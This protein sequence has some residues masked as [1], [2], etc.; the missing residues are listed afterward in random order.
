MEPHTLVDE[1]RDARY[2]GLLL[3]EV[4][5]NADPEGLKRV[6]VHVPGILDPSRWALPLGAM[7]GVHEGV[8]A[9]PKVGSN[10]GVFLVQGHVNFPCYVLGPFGKP[11]GETDVPPQSPSVDHFTL[12]WRDF[13]L[14]F[15]GVPGAEKLTIEDLGSGTRLEVDRTTGNFARVVAGDESATVAGNLQE[16]VAGS[17]TH[18]VVGSRTTAVGGAEAKTVGG[19]ETNTIAG[20]K[21]E[22]VGGAKTDTTALA[23]AETVGLAKTLTAGLSIAITAGGNVSVAAA[24]SVSIVGAAVTTQSSGP[25]NDVAAGLKTSQFL[26]GLSETVVG[27]VAKTVSGADVETIAGIKQIVA[28]V[29]QLGLGPVRYRL[30]DE[31]VFAAWANTHTHASLGAPPD[32]KVLEGTPYPP[33]SMAPDVELRDVVT[34]DLTSS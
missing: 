21:V 6:R 15:N 32:Q 13:H 18:S 25:S 5:D 9:V 2:H 10:V 14:T 8:A 34:R 19:S 17:E 4:V 33:G 31:R 1:T 16:A 11:K 20:S 12:R 27:A 29:L 30:V 3:G 28:A 26:G 23:S 24:G 22:T 7:F